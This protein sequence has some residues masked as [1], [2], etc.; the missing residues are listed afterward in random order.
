[1][2]RLGSHGIKKI[3]WKQLRGDCSHSALNMAGQSP[4]ARAEIGH[5]CRHSVPYS[6]PPRTRLQQATFP[7]SIECAMH[8]L[9]NEEQ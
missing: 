3:V 8:D 6:T 7:V 4:D 1:M 2:L 5:R 9:S